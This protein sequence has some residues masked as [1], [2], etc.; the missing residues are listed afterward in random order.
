[1]IAVLSPGFQ[2]VIQDLGRPGFAHVGVSASGA[3]DPLSFR[4]GNLIVGNAENTPALEMTLVGGEFEFLQR[5]V[6][7]I[8]GSDF[9]PTLDGQAAAMWSPFVVRNGQRL[10]FGATKSGARCYL[11]VRGGLGIK[12]VLGSVSTHIQTKLGGFQGRPLRKGDVIPLTSSSGVRVETAKLDVKEV[13]AWLTGTEIRVTPGLQEDYFSQSELEKFF[14]STF[15]V[16]E[17][18]NRMGLR[19][20]G[21]LIKARTHDI[22][23]E[24]APLGAIQIPPN[25]HPIIL[26]V[27]HQTTGGYPKIANVIA[28]DIPRVG[29]LRPRDRIRFKRV[30][31]DAALQLL[32]QQEALIDSMKKSR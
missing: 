5:S 1:M 31:V 18:S 21:T 16:L 6:V 23:T 20:A 32:R 13:L 12:P 22:I 11:C 26:F 3:A 8:T 27:E 7:T 28:A 25:E 9:G 14:S 17:D 30:T 24:G 15:E 19:L 4:I 2:S 29:Q 10:C